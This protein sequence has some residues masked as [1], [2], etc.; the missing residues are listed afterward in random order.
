M[1][2][3]G[4]I[5][6]W[7]TIIGSITNQSDLVEYISTHGGGGTA[8]VWGSISGNIG[9]QTDLMN[10]VSGYATEQFVTSTL[11]GYATQ[12]WVSSNFLS[13]DALSSYATVQYVDE[14]VA[15]GVNWMGSYVASNYL[16]SSALTGY[17]TQS[18]VSS[19]GYLTSVPE[20]YATQSW[21]ES[22]SYLSYSLF[23][24][25]LT[26]FIDVSSQEFFIGNIIS[27]GE[28]YGL[29]VLS[30]GRVGKLVY[31]DERG[32][33]VQ[34]FMTYQDTNEVV[35][36]YIYW[37]LSYISSYYLSSDAL[38]GYATESWV[39]AQGFLTSVPSEYATQSWV[40][41]NFLSSEALT[42]YATESWVQSQGYLTSH[43]DLT[44]YATESWVSAQGYITSIPSEYATQSWVSSQG[45]I[46]SSALSSYA[47]QS[48]VSE[49]A[50][51]YDFE[52]PFSD[53]NF[54]VLKREYDE[55]LDMTNPLILGYEDNG[56]GTWYRTVAIKDG[57]AGI[58]YFNDGGEGLE[59]TDF[60]EF[61]AMDPNMYPLE[62]Y[63][64]DDS[65]QRY[66]EAIEEYGTYVPLC[67]PILIGVQSGD[68]FMGLM[69]DE[70]GNVGKYTGD[71][72]DDGSLIV[73]DNETFEEFATKDYVD[74]LVGVALNITNDILDQGGEIE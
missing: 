31:N 66:R 42:G 3:P 9:D 10:L 35:G 19:Q 4:M 20:G 41:S 12:S 23:F 45:Y 2:F 44:G 38:S 14:Q 74:S 71:L 54:D 5:T 11:S 49:N 63:N 36:G 1:I 30:D 7:G 61:Y 26:K 17:A 53:L 62:C 51:L 6:T 64:G 68:Q 15:W 33:D 32:F 57:T 47:T 22:Q 48:Y 40:S 16:K 18:W 73:L 25:G 37:T 39:S 29:Y 24:D 34:E 67:D 55:D 60:F 8:A 21:V 56:G 46:T 72:V 52:S 50:V 59:E 13:S 27:E 70:Y 69:V 28:A 58:Q 43:Q 65:W